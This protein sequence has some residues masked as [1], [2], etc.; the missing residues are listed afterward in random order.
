MGNTR[1]AIVK[2]LSV[3]IGAELS[4]CSRAADMLT[5]QFG[6]L[7]AVTSKT[8]KPR[9]LGKWSLHVQCPWRI[10]S[11]SAIFTGRSDL[12]E[13]EEKPDLPFDWSAW[14]FEAG[15]LRDKRLATLFES[16]LDRERAIYRHGNRVVESV[17]ADAFGGA[18]ISMSDDCHFVMFPDGTRSEDWRFFSS[19]EKSTCLVISGGKLQPN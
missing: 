14:D 19:R 3:L 16:E 2:E 15:N 9:Q 1:A 6:P 17:D 8:G 13:P 10:E 18:R 5:L 7:L 12:W 11:D 4:A